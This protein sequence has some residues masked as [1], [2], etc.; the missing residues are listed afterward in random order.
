MCR[1]LQALRCFANCLFTYVQLKRNYERGYWITKI[2]LLE[3]IC[4]EIETKM[5]A[6]PVQGATN[7]E[8]K[9]DTVVS[10]SS[11]S[12]GT[13]DNQQ[14]NAESTSPRPKLGTLIYGYKSF[15]HAT[16]RLVYLIILFAL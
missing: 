1:S 3:H 16:L 5:S 15:L 10:E 2:S 12:V 8:T 11:Q 7:S 14:Q 4:Q 6:E 13:D 9:N